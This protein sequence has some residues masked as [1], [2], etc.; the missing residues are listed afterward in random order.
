MP[1]KP[2]Q[3]PGDYQVEFL[4]AAGAVAHAAAVTVVDAHYR[5]QNVILPPA[6]SSLKSSPEEGAAVHAF[7]KQIS[8]VRYWQEP[9]H[10][11]VAGCMTSPF[12]V[13]RLANGVPTGD[14]HEGIDQR[15]AMGAPVHA[16][17]AGTVHLA[18]QFTRRGGTVGIDHGQGLQSMYLHL[19]KIAV[20]EGQRLQGGDVVGYAGS[21][22][23]STAPHLHWSLYA[24]GQAVNPSQ[25]VKLRA[26]EVRRPTPAKPAS[27]A[28]ES[29][30]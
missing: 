9:L 28:T 27:H 25:W 26:C 13:E 7:M 12:G 4:D 18:G 23:R 29:H 1:V 14:R 20:H 6:V 16:V 10:L 11:P 3:Q 17:A 21:T 24:N 15:A 19:S 8:A 30:P 22:G 5:K 2:D